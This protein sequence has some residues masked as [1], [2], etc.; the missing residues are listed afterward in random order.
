MNEHESR[1]GQLLAPLTAWWS[2]MRSALRGGDVSRKAADALHEL[3][4]SEAAKR[5][6]SALHDFRES[7]AGKRAATRISDLRQSE[8]GQR[9]AS[10]L[11]DLRQ[12]E[13]VRKAEE[14]ARRTLNDLRSSGTGS[15]TSG[16][17]GS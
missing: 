7:D 8:T 3:R 4:D 1:F 15:G 2:K 5:A 16:T 12:R 9:A 10:A 13:S 14:A 11:S 17:S 6:A